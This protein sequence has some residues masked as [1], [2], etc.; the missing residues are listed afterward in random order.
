MEQNCSTVVKAAVENAPPNQ[1][2]MSVL[3]VSMDYKMVLNHNPNEPNDIYSDNSIA[4][5][6]I[7][8]STDRGFRVCVHIHG[9]S[10]HIHKSWLVYVILHYCFSSNLMYTLDRR[11]CTTES[12]N[13]RYP[14]LGV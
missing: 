3:V 7:F 2:T 5:V 4:V 13:L 10:M 8:G 14:L 9:V 11:T 12:L 6:R 1:T